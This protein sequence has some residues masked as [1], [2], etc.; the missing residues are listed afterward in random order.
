MA[1]LICL[2]Y[3]GYLYERIGLN[4]TKIPTFGISAR[5]CN[6]CVYGLIAFY[7]VF[8]AFFLYRIYAMS[9]TA[10]E[11]GCKRDVGKRLPL[12]KPV[13]YETYL[14]IMPSQ[15]AYYAKF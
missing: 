6:H 1:I 8:L 7:V 12:R 10:T 11:M 3:Y 2:L 9:H 14:S 15:Y 13:R 4:W 5:R